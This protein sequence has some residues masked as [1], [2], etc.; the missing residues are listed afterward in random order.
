MTFDLILKQF[1]LRPPNHLHFAQLFFTW[2]E[3]YLTKASGL[4]LFIVFNESM[5]HSKF[6]SIHVFQVA[7]FVCVGD[8]RVNVISRERQLAFIRIQMLVN[9]FL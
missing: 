1:S 3:G 2:S 8:T 9:E 7:G 5:N 6:V 4:S